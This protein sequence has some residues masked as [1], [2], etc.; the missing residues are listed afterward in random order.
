MSVMV[1]HPRGSRRLAAKITA[2]L[3]S[4]RQLDRRGESLGLAPDHPSCTIWLHE[5]C[6][7]L[8]YDSNGLPE[9]GR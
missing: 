8:W 3:R 2:P 7:A 1:S 6:E 5:R 9:G 4:L